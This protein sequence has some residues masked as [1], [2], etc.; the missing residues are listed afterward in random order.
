MPQAVEGRPESLELQSLHALVELAP[1]LVVAEVPQR[2]LLGHVAL[3]G[4]ERRS[5]AED[6]GHDHHQR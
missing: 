2:L 1:Q 3:Q 6:L 5:H 4:H